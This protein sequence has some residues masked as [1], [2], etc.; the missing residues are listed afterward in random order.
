MLFTWFQNRYIGNQ[1]TLEQK[2]RNVFVVFVTAV[3]A[4]F[5]IDLIVSLAT[6]ELVR[7]KLLRKVVG[8][9]I[10]IITPFGLWN[11][12]KETYISDTTITYLLQIVAISN[13]LASLVAAPTRP[14]DQYAIMLMVCIAAMNLKY[15]LWQYITLVPAL[16]IMTYNCTFGVNGYPRIEIAP[17]DPNSLVPE[18][19]IHAR[20]VILLPL[21]ILVVRAHSRAYRMTVQSL[22]CSVQMAKEVSEHMAE[23]NI[24]AAEETLEEY[25]SIENCDKGLC[26]I[27]MV[28]VQNLKK[29]KPHL[30]NYVVTSDS[31]QQ[32]QR[33][34]RS[35][36][37]GREGLQPQAQ[38]PFEQG[39]QSSDD[40]NEMSTDVE[41]D[42]TDDI[43]I[44]TTTNFPNNPIV[45][46]TTTTTTTTTLTNPPSSGIS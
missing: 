17:P 40:N 14:M 32:Q 1:F 27:M 9:F 39:D 26:D 30:P 21:T 43:A 24:H 35:N 5:T 12:H 46:T 44:E 23:Y 13:T 42:D 31:Q 38:P 3:W 28:L 33:R 18:L 41:E 7:S 45:P 8:F 16:I 2:T 11:A 19:L 6:E 15:W 34:R 37:K 29:Y 20:V 4:I 36:R 22:E 25:R 10:S